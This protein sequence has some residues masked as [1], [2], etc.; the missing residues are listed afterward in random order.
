MIKIKIQD[1]ILF[2][3]D[4][5]ITV[6]LITHILIIHLLISYL[7]IFSLKNV[8]QKLEIHEFLFHTT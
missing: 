1:Y 3:N 4:L 2:L 8:F 6:I 5:I 7:F